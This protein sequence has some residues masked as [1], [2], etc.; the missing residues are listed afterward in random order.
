M[1]EADKASAGP[2]PELRLPTRVLRAIERQRERSEILTGWIQA[3]I[4]GILATLY[5]VSPSTSPAD[6]IFRPAP[7]AIGIYA[8]FTALR[9]RLAY[10][11][12]LTPP[13][14][15][16]SAIVDM[17]LLTVTIWGFH[18]EYG[19][20][21]AF[22]LKAPTFAYFFIFIALRTLSFSPAYVLLAGAAAALGWLALLLYA[23]GAPG[24]TDLVTRDYVEYM[25]AAKI[26]V[27]GEVDKIVSL[28]LVSALLALAA[29]RS[30]QLLEQAATVHAAATQ[31]ARYFPPEVAEQLISADE[32]LKP[33]QGEA[34]QAATMFIDL[35]GFSRLTPLLTP[36]ELIALVGDFQHLAVPI[37]QRHRG[38][39]ITYLGD[40]I[41]VT[42]GAVRPTNTYAADAL[43]CTEALVDGVGL[44]I[45]ESCAR[46]DCAPEVGIGVDV[47][48]VICGTIGDEGKFEYAVLGDPVNRAAKLQAHT[49]AAGVRALTTRFALEQARAQG[50]VDGRCHALAG[51][52]Q[53]AGIDAPLELV[54]IA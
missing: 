52:Q 8:A 19:Q 23:L 54:A 34:R 33:G 9:L 30:R 7:W 27:G 17:A 24:G 21:A 39:I 50:Y 5:F 14:R 28:L 36:K 22:Y 2:R 53:V 47:G 32:L 38:A 48:T 12:R 45:T 31:M 10:A 43:R 49:K 16:A 40:G 20:P 26:L 42:F 18:I 25:T 41:M 51:G 6:V 35:R 29:M 1:T 4:I 46:G 11:G 13:L 3:A 37:I 15:A 44:W